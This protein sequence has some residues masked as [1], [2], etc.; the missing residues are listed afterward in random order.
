[1]IIET[2]ELTLSFGTLG[3]RIPRLTIDQA[4]NVQIPGTLTVGS[5]AQTIT[6]DTDGSTV[7]FA[8]NVSDWHQV[9]LNGN[10]TLAVTGVTV[11]Q[12]FT[13]VLI[14]DGVTGSRTVTWFSGIKWAGGSAPTLTTTAGKADIFTFKCVSGGSF[15][16]FVAGQNF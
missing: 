6:T 5:H 13:I 4:G 11:G 9:T 10:R 8:L 2:E 7:T 15:Y 12:Q 16:G 14:Q 1:M 3:N